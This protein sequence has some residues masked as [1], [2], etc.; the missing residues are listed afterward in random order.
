M[1]LKLNC[2]L[3][4]WTVHCTEKK[5]INF[6]QQAKTLLFL[7]RLISVSEQLNKN[8]KHVGRELN[9]WSLVMLL[10]EQTHA[11]RT[12]NDT[13]NFATWNNSVS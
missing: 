1:S 4:V 8:R 2:V 3:S 9:Y 12:D 7:F 10:V 13:E 5:L 11:N 6:P